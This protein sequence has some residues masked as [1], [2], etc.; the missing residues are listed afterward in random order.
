[1]A[2]VLPEFPVF[3]PEVDETSVGIRWTKW[4]QRLENLLVA[5]D[6]T[7]NERKQAVMLHY[8]GTKV[9]D[10]FSTLILPEAGDDVYKKSNCFKWVF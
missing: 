8:A 5:L 7:N 3:D 1:M 9:S 6:I 2:A 10:I 4:V